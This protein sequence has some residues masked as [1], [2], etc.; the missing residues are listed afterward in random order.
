MLNSGLDDSELILANRAS[1]Y[2]PR[3]KNQGKWKAKASYVDSSWLF[4]AGG[5]YST[6]GDL[7][8]WEK[9]LRT[10]AVLP[11]A[12]VAQ[13]WS[14]RHGDY[15]YGWQL[16]APSP[17]WL[18]RRVVFHAG[19]LTGFATD[20]LIYPEERVAVVVLANLLPVPLADIARDLSAMTL[21]AR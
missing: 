11:P 10:G 18:N 4:S 17:K 19:G 8:I 3:Q 21:D 9:A 12:E 15:G 20:L 16:L 2:R 5:V 1:G 14:T 6:V 7:L 13:M